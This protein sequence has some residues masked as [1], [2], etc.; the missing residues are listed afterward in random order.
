MTDYQPIII[1][2]AGRSGTNMLRDALVKLPGFATWP[3]DEINYIWRH[4][5]RSH[6]DEEFS[7]EM[8][9]PIAKPYINKAFDKMAHRTQCTHLVEKTCANTLRI[10]FV[11]AVIPNA[12]YINIVRDGRDVVASAMKRWTANL[13]IGYLA[14]KARFVPVGDLPYYAVS[15]GMQRLKKLGADEKALPTWGPRYAGMIQDRKNKTLAEVCAL[16]WVRCVEK[17]RIDLEKLETDKVYNLKYEEFVRDP[18]RYLINLGEFTGSVFDKNH[19]SQIVSDIRVQ[20]TGIGFSH[21]ENENN[22]LEIVG[23]CNKRLG[24]Y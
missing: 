14:Q 24:Y 16:Q 18:S 7:A 13:D 8:A 4:G 21:L 17:S 20:P 5:N 22:A 6:P 2:G 1:V 15:Y 3:C 11:N 19:I 10:P 12:K 9:Q 23:N